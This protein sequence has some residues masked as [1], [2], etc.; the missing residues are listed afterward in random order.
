MSRGMQDCFRQHPETY[1]SEFEDDEEEVEDELRARQA[2]SQDEV[3]PSEPAKASE[4]LQQAIPEH[5][6]SERV[7]EPHRDSSNA[8]A[9]KVKVSGDEG[10]ELLPKAVHDATSK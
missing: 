1:A 8:T 5:A 3:S 7:E 4:P 9:D 10:E 6:E 2:V